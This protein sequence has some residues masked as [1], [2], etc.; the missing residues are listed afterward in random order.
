ML[1][2]ELTVSEYFILEKIYELANNVYLREKRLKEVSIADLAY[3][4][5]YAKQLSSKRR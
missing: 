4:K 5:I 3:I 2:D 1:K